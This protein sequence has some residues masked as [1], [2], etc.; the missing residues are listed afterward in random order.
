MNKI[1]NNHDRK[2]K[3]KIIIK[4]IGGLGNQLYQ[5][6]SAY[7]IAEALGL[8]LCLDI[9]KYNKYKTHKYELEP[10]IKEYKHK[11]YSQS[12]FHWLNPL[13][14][15][16]RKSKTIGYEPRIIRDARRRNIYLDGYFQSLYY[17]NSFLPNIRNNF[18]KLENSLSDSSKS[19]YD[20]I[21][22]NDVT[23]IHIRGTDKL[24][25]STNLRIYGEISKEKIESILEKFKINYPETKY[26]CF[27]DDDN[28][29]HTILKDK[30]IKYTIASNKSRKPWEDLFL[31]SA[32]KRKILSNST[33]SLWAAYL[34]NHNEENVYIPHPF[35]K[36]PYHFS[37][38]G[39]KD[40]SNFM[41]PNWKVF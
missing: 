39:H 17:F 13:F 18:S 24:I 28:Y 26:L 3:G 14:F 37:V 33:F 30:N 27:T 21:T 23:A 20:I 4:I 32:C 38:A 12:K 5:F 19:L 6:F 9:S 10:I 40:S 1:N 2:S 25:S 35:Y 16:R 36:L 31:L 7:S 34:S 29:A 15:S 8:E 11:I 22:N 41:L